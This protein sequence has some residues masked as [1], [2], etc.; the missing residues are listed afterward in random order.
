MIDFASLLEY[1]DV[2]EYCIAANIE[3][4]CVYIIRFNPLAFD[5]YQ[6][7]QDL[8]FNEEDFLCCSFPVDGFVV[9]TSY[10]NVCEKANVVLSIGLRPGAT[11]FC[12][13]S[14]I[15]KTEDGYTAEPMLASEMINVL[16]KIVFADT[17]KHVKLLDFRHE[18]NYESKA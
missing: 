13:K 17:L 4:Q 11:D 1:S 10:E 16:E 6:N 8:W 15:W 9:Y 12:N 3:T 14:I 2:P 5:F 18:D 7:M